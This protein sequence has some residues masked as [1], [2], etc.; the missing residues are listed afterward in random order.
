M[1]EEIITTVQEMENISVDT[2][3]LM[4]GNYNMAGMPV[5]IAFVCPKGENVPEITA[6]LKSFADA[7]NL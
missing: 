2:H 6:I 4:C 3:Q 1:K 5:F 7:H